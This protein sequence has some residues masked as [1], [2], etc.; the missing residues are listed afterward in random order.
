MRHHRNPVMTDKINPFLRLRRKRRRLLQV[1]PLLRRY[2]ADPVLLEKAIADPSWGSE[3]LPILP[4]LL[5]L[6]QGQHKPKSLFPARN[7]MSVVATVFEKKDPSP[8]LLVVVNPLVSGHHAF[9]DRNGDHTPR[10]AA[11]TTPSHRPLLWTFRIKW[12]W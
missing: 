10:G 12:M 8:P 1:P 5:L 9:Q 2:L 11:T 4:F 7:C 6:L 3:L